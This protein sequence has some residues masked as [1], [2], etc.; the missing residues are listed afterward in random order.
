MVTRLVHEDSQQRV[1]K[2]PTADP[3]LMQQRRDSQALDAWRPLPA[4]GPIKADIELAL[5][6]L[7]FNL[8]RTTNLH[9]APG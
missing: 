3:G 1:A 9:G 6:T 2:R 7:A 4:Q 5:L 8:K